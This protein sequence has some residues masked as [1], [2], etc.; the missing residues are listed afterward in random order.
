MQTVD[1]CA[2]LCNA[3]ERCEF[4][5]WCPA[6]EAAGCGVPGPNATYASTVPAGGCL[7]TFAPNKDVLAYF[8]AR[9]SPQ[10]VAFTSG[11]W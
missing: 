9:G 3:S 2:E 8:I 6:T 5:A 4:Y 11:G 7:Y 10:Q 1:A